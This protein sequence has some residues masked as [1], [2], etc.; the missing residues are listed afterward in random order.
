MQNDFP[1][2]ERLMDMRVREELQQAK[3]RRLQR[4]AREARQG[5]LSRQRCWILRQLGSVFV[6]LGMRPLQ[7]RLPHPLSDTAQGRE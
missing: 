4:E 5:W 6:L 1:F 7:S 2:G 3:K